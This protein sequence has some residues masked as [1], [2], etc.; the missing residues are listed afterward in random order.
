MGFLPQSPW[1]AKKHININILL[2]LR[3]C[4]GGLKMP[5]VKKSLNIMVTTAALLEIS[6][7]H[8]NGGSLKEATTH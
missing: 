2:S 5:L 1:F 7:L 8:A 4:A 3:P 6:V